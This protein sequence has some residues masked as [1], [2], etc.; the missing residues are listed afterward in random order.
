[1]NPFKGIFKF[2]LPDTSIP[3][4]G[5]IFKTHTTEFSPDQE[6]D[7]DYS[8]I[9]RIVADERVTSIVGLVCAMVEESYKRIELEPEND[10]EDY[11][12]DSVEIEM[13]KQAKIIAKKL[14]FRGKFHDYAWQLVT[15]GDVFERYELK[16][17][18]KES[19]ILPIP[20][21]NVRVITE[22]RQAEDGNSDL[23]IDEQMI[24]IRNDDNADENEVLPKEKYIH[25]SIKNHGVWRKDK[26]GGDT[27]SIYSRPPVAVLSKLIDWKTKTIEN[28]ILWKNKTVPRVKHTLKMPAITPNRF[29]GT[30]EEKIK[31]AKD[32][33]HKIIEDF[34]NSTRDMRPDADVVT[35][36]AVESG[37]L[38]P[39]STNYQKPNEVLNQ[40]NAAI[41]TVHGIP[42]GLTGG[43][44]TS[45]SMESAGIFAGLRIK[46]ISNKIALALERILKEQLL[47]SGVGAT[48]ENIDRIVIRIDDSLTKELFDKFKIA[49]SAKAVGVFTKQ[50]L[51][52]LVGYSALPLNAQDLIPEEPHNVGPKQDREGNLMREGA[53]ANETNRSSA[54]RQSN[55]GDANREVKKV[56]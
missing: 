38:E 22:R 48:E 47:I 6:P 36:D 14:D 7:Y 46:H 55:A 30:M 39:K 31:K 45:M 24:D 16:S 43:K 54:S 17:D 8:T 5:K 41:N 35:S 4:G 23:I 32:E 50:E 42:E 53:D 25:L 40:I 28:D 10:F 11:E 20:L 1:M 29:Q 12:L 26:N 13:L 51:R 21:N 18:A 19:V 44:D 2:A 49:L 27:F 56:E 33:A 37:I 52:Q 15:H 34:I 9:E 3:R